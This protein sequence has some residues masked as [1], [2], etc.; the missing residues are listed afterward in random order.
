MKN[1]QQRELAKQQTR[2]F[3]EWENVTPRMDP[4]F[5]LHDLPYI[6]Q[7]TSIPHV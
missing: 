1:Q 6:F 4:R 2:T 7:G 5:A 3:A